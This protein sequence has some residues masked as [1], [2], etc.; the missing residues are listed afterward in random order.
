MYDLAHIFLKYLGILDPLALSSSK[1]NYFSEKEMAQNNCNFFFYL[2]LKQW[3]WA[4]YQPS[5]RL[6]LEFIKDALGERGIFG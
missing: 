5:S 4:Y 3:F 1:W 6:I 2:N